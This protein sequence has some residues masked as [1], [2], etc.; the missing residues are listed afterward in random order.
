MSNKPNEQEQVKE[1]ACLLCGVQSI[2]DGT[3]KPKS[4]TCLVAHMLADRAINAGYRKVSSPPEK[5]KDDEGEAVK[6]IIKLE[7]QCLKDATTPPEK[8][9]E[10]IADT[11][12][13]YDIVHG[14]ATKDC[15]VDSYK[16][17]ARSIA[18][19]L[20]VPEMKLIGEEERNSY[21]DILHQIGKLLKDNG[22]EL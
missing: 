16:E 8:L 10:E 14:H 3:V 12:R 11:I 4:E 18:S 1:L 22:I 13:D 6:N 15:S 7:N 19:L 20:P 17:V 2:C 5:M 9:V 21:A